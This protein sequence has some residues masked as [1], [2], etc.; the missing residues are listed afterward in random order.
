MK[1]FVS[2]SHTDKKALG[3]LK[4]DLS[5]LGM[6]CFLAHDDINIGEHDL[7]RIKKEIADCDI[8]LIIG[9]KESKQS[10]FCN[11]EI[12]MAIAYKKHIIS[13]IHK[14][15]APWGFT[16]R[17]QAIKYQDIQT[18][19][20]SKLYN[21]IIKLQQY[22]QYYEKEIKCLNTLKIKGFIVEQDKPQY[23]S[24]HKENYNTNR[25][26][27]YNDYGYYTR[28]KVYENGTRIG[29]IAIGYKDQEYGKH[30]IEQLPKWFPFLKKIFFSYVDIDCKK[31]VSKDKRKALGF[32]LNDLRY[33]IKSA[34]LYLK[35]DVC[36]KIF[37]QR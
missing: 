8:F 27:N 25:K 9:N 22:K 6:D 15:L 26:Y 21:T 34:K 17:Q 18:D 4:R 10:D 31:I 28:C 33:N 37:I 29:D 5:V 12:G 16:E 20:Y 23:L 35:E 30:T 36:R 13:T 24:I 11:Q 3:Q 2:H 1:I 7:E 32:L 14:D 19:L